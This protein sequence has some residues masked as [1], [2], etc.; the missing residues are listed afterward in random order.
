MRWL[1][2]CASAPDAYAPSGMA[3]AQPPG[4]GLPEQA[5]SVHALVMPLEVSVSDTTGERTCED[6]GVIFDG[7][8]HS[9]P[10]VDPTETREW[11]HNLAPRVDVHRRPR[12]RYPVAALL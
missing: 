4:P 10:D 5:P 11:L 12:A 9:L 1:V 8:V 2:L 7:F 6:G 3:H